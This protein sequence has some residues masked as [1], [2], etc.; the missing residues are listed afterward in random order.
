M[1]ALNHGAIVKMYGYCLNDFDEQNNHVIIMDYVSNG[2]L[3]KI[4][5]NERKGL[6]TKRWDE[7]QKLI[8]LYGIA[9]GMAYSSSHGILHSDLKPENILMTEELYPKITD[10]D[11][12]KLEV[13]DF[14]QSFNLSGR[15]MG[16]PLYTAPEILKKEKDR[17]EYTEK[18]DVYSYSMILYHVVTGTVPFKDLSIPEIY[19]MVKKGKRPK[20]PSY[21]NPLISELITKCWDKM[22]DQRPTF[23]EIADFLRSDEFLS[24]VDID[25][26]RFQ[27]YVEYINDYKNIYT[28]SKFIR[29]MTQAGNYKIDDDDEVM[30]NPGNIPILNLSEYDQGNL[31]GRGRYSQVIRIQNK[32]TKKF[33][34]QKFH[35]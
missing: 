10:F 35:I 31:L 7:T 9:S 25:Q 23:K 28:K 6:S 2:D 15:E 1:S 5:D 20:I 27:V 18:L 19:D 22:Q 4:L 21:V 8:I 29:P 24:S 14:N 17:S 26:D 32:A 33:W 30:K 11:S 12:A 34:Q 16:S 13:D 3:Q